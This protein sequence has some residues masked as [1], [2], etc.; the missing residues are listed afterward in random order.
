MA[1]IVWASCPALAAD[2]P[3]YSPI[4]ERAILEAVEDLGA[5][6]VEASRLRAVIA[7]DSA[8]ADALRQ[9]IAALERV[10][11]I[12][13]QAL[14]AAD[15]LAAIQDR[16]VKVNRDLAAA[17]DLRAQRADERADRAETVS[18]WTGPIGLILGIAATAAVAVFARP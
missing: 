8:L 15:K 9:Q 6:R 7:A 14:A 5:L 1:S 3:S 11:T 10:S 16:A 18:K 2:D 17:S 13:D 4:E 12:Q